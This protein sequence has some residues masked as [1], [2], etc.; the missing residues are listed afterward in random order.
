MKVPPP[1]SHR[2][3][4]EEKILLVSTRRSGE[5]VI[6][7]LMNQIRLYQSIISLED[8]ADELIPSSCCANYS[9]QRFAHL[10]SHPIMSNHFR[11][12]SSEQ[13]SEQTLLMNEDSEMQA[14]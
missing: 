10:I 9:Y 2:R 12:H 1:N 6:S 5:Q 4:L 14:S 11:V 13:S 3:Q 8:S 7:R